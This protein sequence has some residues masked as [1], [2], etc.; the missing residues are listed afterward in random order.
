MVKYSIEWTPN[1]DPLYHD[2]SQSPQE[3][4]IDPPL[5]DTPI[6][7]SGYMVSLERLVGGRAKKSF[8]RAAKSMGS[9]QSWITQAQ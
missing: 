9:A 4:T 1:P 6:S 5:L 8:R 2:H 3:M 7:V